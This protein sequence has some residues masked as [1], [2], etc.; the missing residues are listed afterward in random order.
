M[1]NHFDGHFEQGMDPITAFGLRMKCRSDTGDAELMAQIGSKLAD[2]SSDLQSELEGI[3]IDV[4]KEK[5]VPFSGSSEHCYYF[6]FVGYKT[7][8]VRHLINRIL[9][10]VDVMGDG[11]GRFQPLPPQ[12]F[13]LML[14]NY[15]CSSRRHDIDTLPSRLL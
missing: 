6:R 13:R 15:Y 1:A 3:L 5:S 7:I 11:F 2:C 9:Q 8:F 14:Q 12:F 4:I 10:L